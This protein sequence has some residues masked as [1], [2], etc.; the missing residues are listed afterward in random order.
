MF[1]GFHKQSLNTIKKYALVLALPGII[2]LVLFTIYPIINNFILSFYEEDIYGNFHWVGLGNYLWFRKDPY[3]AHIIGNTLFYTLMTPTISVL[4]AIPI[5]VTLK[6]IGSKW[7]LLIMLSAFI[8]WT[9]A[10]MAWYLFLNPDYGIA[11]YLF[12]WGLLKTN[13]IQSIWTIL[14]INVWETLPTAVL[15]IYSGLKSI[16]RSVEEAAYAD[17]LIGIRKFLSV[18][19]PLT[20]PQIL[21]A[22]TL[23]MISGLF[24]FVPIY[25][26]TSQ[27]GPRILDNLIFYAYEKF[28]GG[29]MGYAAALIT[30]M[31]IISTA[32]AIAYLKLMTSEKVMRFQA[33]SFVP[34]KEVPKI[35]HYLLLVM[36]LAFII[37][38]IAWMVIVSLKSPYE[39]IQI[40]PTIIPRKIDIVNYL[41]AVGTSCSLGRIA[42]GGLPYLITSIGISTFNVIVTIFI[43]SMLAYAMRVHRIGGDK[44]VTFLLYLLATPTIIYIIPLYLILKALNIINTWYGLMLVYPIMTVPYNT[45]L[46]YNYYKSFPKTMEEAAMS[47]GMNLIRAFFKISLPLN[48]SGLGVAAVYAFIFSWGALIFPLAFTYTPLDLSNPW[49]LSGAQT[50]S[51][52]IAMLVAPTTMSYGVIAAAGV[53]SLIPPLILLVLARRSLERFWGVR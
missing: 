52:Y 2:Y 27:A 18:D 10:A 33:P 6:R 30:I 1:L 46:L 21:T 49:K 4:L 22:F 8:P 45:W 36:V 25:I 38:P 43:A 51:V 23:I 29:Q 13:P 44:L 5:S 31:T 9:T 24:T 15:I 16:P 34:S 11:Y 42:G 17:G 39:V 3:L 48:R 7:L 41:C 26:G 47:D 35:F 40:P 37:T 28:W 19:L 12:K 14:L 53:I 50:Y 20:I 32:I